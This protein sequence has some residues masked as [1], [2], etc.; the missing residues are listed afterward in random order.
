MYGFQVPDNATAPLTCLETD[1]QHTTTLIYSAQI[2]TH[3]VTDCVGF[4]L[5][6]QLLRF[7]LANIDLSDRSA[8]LL[9]FDRPRSDVAAVHRFPAGHKVLRIRVADKAIS[10]GLSCDLVSD[11]FRFDKTLPA[12]LWS[13]RFHKVFVIHIVTEITDEESEMLWIPLH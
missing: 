7:P 9:N 1:A 2:Q 6:I 5:C 10:S 8:G 3:L 4:L 12:F 11:D 13:K